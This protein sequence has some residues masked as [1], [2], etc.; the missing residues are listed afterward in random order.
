MVFPLRHTE[1]FSC[2]NKEIPPVL[3]QNSPEFFVQLDAMNREGEV[4][5]SYHAYI[6]ARKLIRDSFVLGNQ[7]EEAQMYDPDA[8]FWDETDA[9]VDPNDEP[10][11]G[12]MG[13]KQANANLTY[14]RYA[15]SYVL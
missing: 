8:E 1:L 12:A 6:A 14:V 4:G 11:D 15:Y 3:L 9:L 13:E 5:S 7:S 2:I 10:V